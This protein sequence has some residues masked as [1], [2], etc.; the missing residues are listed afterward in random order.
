MV[1]NKRGDIDK[2]EAREFVD[3]NILAVVFK[4]LVKDS[5]NAT[6]GKIRVYELDNGKQLQVT[7]TENFE[8]WFINDDVS[9][10]IPGRLTTLIEDLNNPSIDIR[11]NKISFDESR[12]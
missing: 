10:N 9:H 8:Y 1:E 7:I 6:V 12:V 5:T 3:K 2:E 11:E 4:L